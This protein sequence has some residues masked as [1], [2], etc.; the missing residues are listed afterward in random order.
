MSVISLQQ[1][2]RH[3]A[4][5]EAALDAIVTMDGEGRIVDFNAAAERTFGWGREEARGRVLSELIIPPALRERHETALARYL[6]TGEATVLGRRL[7]L[8]ALRRDGSEIPVELTVS[9]ADVDGEPLFVGYLRDLTERPRPAGRPRGGRGA[10]PPARRAGPD[11]HLHLRRRR[12][13]RR[14]LHQPADRAVDRLRAG[15]VDLGPRL[16]RPRDPP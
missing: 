16:L 2:S 8:S 13:P 10:L 1:I 5:L 4:M 3:A 7:E 12:G 6:A 11:R 9:R 14:P 15:G